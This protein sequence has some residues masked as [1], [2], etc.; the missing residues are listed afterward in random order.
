[1]CVCVCVCVC[2]CAVLCMC[3]P[4]V[5]MYVSMC[6]SAVLLQCS[7]GHPHRSSPFPL[8]VCS[9]G[10]IGMSIQPVIRD[11][12]VVKALHTKHACTMCVG[13]AGYTHRCTFTHPCS[14]LT[15]SFTCLHVHKGLFPLCTQLSFSSFVVPSPPL[16][17]SPPPPSI[18][19]P[20][21][22]PPLLPSH[23]FTSSLLQN[24]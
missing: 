15:L 3:L 19:L 21:S 9:N 16:L 2:V 24:L 8:G 7:S 12:Y 20:P 14:L 1:M 11:M 18:P 17:P 4:V 10:S 23:P 13:V 6:A 5:A 22:P